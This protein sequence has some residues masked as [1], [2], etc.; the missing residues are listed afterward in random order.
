MIID[1]IVNNNVV[2]V[3]DSKSKE[4]VVMGRGIG[5]KKKPGDLIDKDNIEKIFTMDNPS[6][7]Q[8]LI[9][10]LENTPSEY[11][12]I[13]EEIVKHAQDVLGKKLNSSIYVL[14]TDH[15]VFAVDRFKENIVLQNPMI[16]EIK[17]LYKDEYRLGQWSINL[18]KDKLDIEL[19]EDEAAFIA[20]HIVNASL[21]EEMY[22]TMNITILTKDILKI[23]KTHFNLDFNEDSLDYIRLV[24]H[25]KF[26]SQRV[27]KK[28]QL[29]L[30]DDDIYNMI[31]SK[32]KEEKNCVD[33]ISKYTERSFNY[34]LSKQEIIY[35]ILHIKKVSS[36]N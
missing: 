21:G 4:A 33:K 10:L 29:K 15:I 22:N 27:F 34:T 8:K 13:T 31:V 14:L 16:W 20:L 25:L 24:T 17:T 30:E 28:E 12:L 3:L 19:P 35:L 2:T 1:K 6:K 36:K 32:Y 23:I 5:F 18:I 7:N 26:F 9:E 11:L